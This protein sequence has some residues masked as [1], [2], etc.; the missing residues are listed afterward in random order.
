[1]TG[2]SSS[3]RVRSILM[4]L[5]AF[6]ACLHLFDLVACTCT[7]FLQHAPCSRVHQMQKKVGLKTSSPMVERLF[8]MSGV[9]STMLKY[10]RT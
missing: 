10:G 9:W 5:E 2:S 4:D 6:S 3:L 1:M 7:R 8:R